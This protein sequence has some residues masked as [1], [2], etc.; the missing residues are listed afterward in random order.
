MTKNF[1]TKKIRK[2]IDKKINVRCQFPLD[3]FAFLRFGVFL[4]EGSSKTPFCT[5]F[6]ASAIKTSPKKIKVSCS[7]KVLQKKL[8]LEGEVFE[9]FFWGVFELPSPRNAQKRNKNNK[10]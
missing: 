10:K 1:I 5:F 4:S 6:V 9:N 3:C 8:I 7:R 2:K